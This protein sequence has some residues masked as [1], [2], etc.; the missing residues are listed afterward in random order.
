MLIVSEGLHAFFK[1]LYVSTKCYAPE[2]LHAASSTLDDP[3]MLGANIENV[4][5]QG[6]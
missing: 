3:K 1:S 2:K 6:P 4:I 5:V